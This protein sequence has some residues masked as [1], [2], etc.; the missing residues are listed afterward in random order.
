MNSAV[1]VLGTSRKTISTVMNYTDTFVNCP[2]LGVK[3]R[4]IEPNLP[5][6]NGSPYTSPYML[7]DL[8]GVDYTLLPLKRI[9]AFTESFELHSDYAD[10]TQAANL[11]GFGDN[12]YRVSRYINKRFIACTVGGIGMKLLF[13]QN[14]LSKGGRKPVMCLDTSDLNNTPVRYKSVAECAKAIGST[15]TSGLIKNYIRPSIPFKGKYL[16]SYTVS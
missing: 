10:S 4:F 13:A 9:Y 5:M 3:C 2:K 12:Y 7:P 11:C 15:D 8:Q 14:P 16:I 1:D 6:K